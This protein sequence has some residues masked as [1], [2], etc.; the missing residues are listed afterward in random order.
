MGFQT[1]EL[2]NVFKQRAPPGRAPKRGGRGSLEAE[3]AGGGRVL[4]VHGAPRSWGRV[5][6]IVAAT[7][8]A[9]RLSRALRLAAHA[10][11]TGS[12]RYLGLVQALPIPISFSL[13]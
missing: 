5:E 6:A 2:L 11:V 10:E 3:R 4:P 13:A 12:S 1:I 8:K 7:K 9:R